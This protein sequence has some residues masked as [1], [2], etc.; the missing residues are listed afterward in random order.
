MTAAKKEH[1]VGSVTWMTRFMTLSTYNRDGQAPLWSYVEDYLY[2][3]KKCVLAL[4]VTG[5]EMQ[6]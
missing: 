1:K 3:R 5:F 6:L 2:S 4:L